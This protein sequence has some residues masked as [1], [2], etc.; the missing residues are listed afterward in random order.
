MK[1]KKTLS[2]RLFLQILFKMIIA[3]F[4]YTVGGVLIYALATSIFFSFS[5]DGT[6]PLYLLAAGLQGH[7]VLIAFIYFILGNTI[8]VLYHWYKPFRYLQ[9]IVDATEVVHAQNAQLV[10]LSPQL[11]ELEG[12]LNQL[13][14]TAMNNQR[15][16]KDAE[17]RKNDLVTYLAH[18]LKT[19]ITSVI[20][21][22]TLLRD[23]IEI[24]PTLRQHYLSIA[25]DKA[26]RLDDLINEFFEITRFNLSHISL[27]KKQINLTLMLQQLIYEFKPMLKEKDL[28][29]VMS[30][31]EAISFRCDP[32][33]L[34]RVFDNLLRN[35]VNYS[36][37]HSAITI[38]AIVKEN[39]IMLN[40][41]NTGDTIS[42]EK[43]NRLFDQFYRLDTSR[44]TKQGGAGLGLAIAREIV[45]L[46]GGTIKAFSKDD[47]IRFQVT[48][49]VEKM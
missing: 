44:S 35:A 15:A 34:Q 29:C 3:C 32:D 6:E 20:G 42:P 26:E 22:L 9:E 41:E 10:M 38:E 1:T 46:H 28:H 24:S 25:L 8:I 30:V 45:V 36:F 31:P 7:I 14:I 40:F 18:D 2:K 16:A 23:E 4:F 43:L 33:K 37:P 48:L 39:E 13:K 27:E 11:S 47:H 49:P 5:W 19:P 12:E 17:Q 21:Y